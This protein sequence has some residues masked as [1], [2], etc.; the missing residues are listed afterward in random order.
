MLKNKIY[1]FSIYLLLFTVLIIAVCF[2]SFAEESDTTEERDIQTLALT[3][4]AYA[5]GEGKE[6]WPG[7]QLGNQ[8]TVFHYHNGHV[9]AL[10]LQLDDSKLLNGKPLWERHF[11]G[12]DSILFCARYPQSLPPMHNHFFIENEFAFVFGLDHDRDSSHLPIL[13]FIHERFHD[14]QF[15]AFEKEIKTGGVLSDYQREEILVGMEIE[16]RIL[17][18]FLLADHLQEKMEHLKDYLA[19]SETRRHLLRNDS[20]KWEDHMQK[21]EG[22]ADYVSVKTF[23]MLKIIPDFNPEQTL[24]LMREKKH[25]GIIFSVQDAMKGRHYFVGAVLGFALDFLEKAN[26]K[27]EIARENKS[28]QELLLKAIPMDGDEIATR[29]NKIKRAMDWTGIQVVIRNKI[30]KAKQDFG[31]AFEAFSSQEGI[32]VKIGKPSG[33]MAS[34]GRHQRSYQIEQQKILVEDTSLAG[35]EDRTWSL[36]FTKIPYVLEERNGDRIFKMQPDTL[37]VLDDREMKA[38]EILESRS[39]LQFSR[40]KFKTE[41]CELISE[42]SGAVI[43]ENGIILLKFN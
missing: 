15:G 31:Q 38:E 27:L 35:S 7:F 29:T 4:R 11:F 14:F 21:M 16:H 17:T 25:H 30:E 13:T 1:S 37:V 22:L 32:L 39:L 5:Q 19:V 24:L 3:I 26:W 9:Y 23:Q 12:E 33:R 8:P 28:L 43:V 42:R 18:E 40:I 10:G 41:H 34:G 36:R 2:S 6:I 20:I